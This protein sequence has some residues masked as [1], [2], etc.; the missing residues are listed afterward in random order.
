MSPSFDDRVLRPVD[1]PPVALEEGNVNPVGGN[2]GGGAPT[3]RQQ[4]FRLTLLMRPYKILFK[5][6][7]R[8]ASKTPPGAG[9][10]GM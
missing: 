9:A 5:Y 10:H 2:V 4:V 6:V 3:L 8:C 7:Y 1:R